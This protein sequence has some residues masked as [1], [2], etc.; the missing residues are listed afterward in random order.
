MAAVENELAGLGQVSNSKSKRVKCL[1]CGKEFNCWPG[2][3]EQVYLENDISDRCPRC[4][5]YWSDLQRMY[6]NIYRYGKLEKWQDDEANMTW[7]RWEHRGFRPDRDKDEIRR[8]L[9][10]TKNGRQVDSL[11]AQ[12]AL[13]DIFEGIRRKWENAAA[14]KAG[15]GNSA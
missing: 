12:A 11:V 6:D 2:G 5:L 4:G 1:C 9:E 14:A 7:N 3:S 10:R 13:N 8:R 15:P